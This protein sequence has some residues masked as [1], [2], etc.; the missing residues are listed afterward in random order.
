MTI[1]GIGPA[2]GYTPLDL[3]IAQSDE[4]VQKVTIDFEKMI[5]QGYGAENAVE[6]ALRRHSLSKWDFTS[7]DWQKLSR[8][9]ENVA[10]SKRGY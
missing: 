5:Q 9:V 1:S 3:F 10:A 8:H 4:N 7:G 2:T 6:E